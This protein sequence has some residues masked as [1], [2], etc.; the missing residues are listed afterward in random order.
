MRS[1]G[2]LEHLPSVD[3]IA[4]LLSM[5]ACNSNTICD[6]EE[7]PIGKLHCFKV[8]QRAQEHTQSSECLPGEC[9]S[10]MHCCETE[11]N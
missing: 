5:L 8:A 2:E 7:H 9:M 11:L 6:E 1:D 10:T 4:K 3:E